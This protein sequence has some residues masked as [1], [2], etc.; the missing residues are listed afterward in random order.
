MVKMTVFNRL[1]WPQALRVSPQVGQ[2]EMEAG[3]EKQ[4]I[5]FRSFF[6]PNLVFQTKILVKAENNAL[7][8]TLNALQTMTQ[9]NISIICCFVLFEKFFV[10]FLL[11]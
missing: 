7:K 5:K 10:F 4:K 6:L 1:L 9:K 3:D 2:L 11:S 8:H